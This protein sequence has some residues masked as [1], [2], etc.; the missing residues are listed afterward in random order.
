M[1]AA[2]RRTGRTRQDRSPTRSGSQA[3]RPP[4]APYPPSWVDRLTSWVDRLPGPAW[5]AYAVLAAFLCLA[6]LGVQ[7]MAGTYPVGTIRRSL[8]VGAL[9]TPY[10]LALITY[11]DRSA[12][13]AMNAFRPTLRGDESTFRYLTYV[14]TTIP[15]RQA[16]LGSV[17][18]LLGGLGLVVVAAS[19][20]PL[21]ASVVAAEPRL[22]A[23]FRTLFEVGPAPASFLLTFAIL[24]MNW[25]T[26][27]AL[28][29]HAVRRLTLV[30]RI[31]ERHT[32]VDLFRQRPLYALSQ[33]TAQTTIGGLIVVYGIASVPAYLSQPTGL[34]TIALIM[35]L[36]SASFALPLIGVHRVLVREKDGREES[37]ADRLNAAGAELHQ[38][39]DRASYKGMDELNKAIQGLEI[40]HRMVHAMPTWPW[41]PETLRTVLVAIFL[42]I[43]LWLLQFAL[44]RLLA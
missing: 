13:A 39:I 41:Q 4:P 42:P 37:I 3:G 24:V 40:E 18:V 23:G 38:R 2:A 30:A 1:T 21:P 20:I 5:L 28:V 43:I 15:P 17:L 32:N 36:G 8:I 6:T 12:V 26:G 44:Q 19:W 34:V 33:L 9:V 22:S 29:V 11:L 14:L 31:Y 16:L 25:W 7:W 10:V 27:G 35:T